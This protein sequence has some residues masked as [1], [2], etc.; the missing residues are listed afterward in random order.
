MF[1]VNLGRYGSAEHERDLKECALS[2]VAIMDI[3]SIVSTAVG[4]VPLPGLKVAFDTFQWIWSSV[5]QVQS[6]KAQLIQL[7]SAIAELLTTLQGNLRASLTPEQGAS[8]K[9]LQTLLNEISSFVSGLQQ[10]HFLKALFRKDEVS[11]AITA[12]HERIYHACDAF[13]ISSQINLQVWLAQSE[14]TKRADYASL[15]LLLQ[16][17]NYDQVAMFDLLNISD[18]KQDTL[19]TMM[20]AL[21]QAVTRISNNTERMFMQQAVRVIQRYSTSAQ[22][23]NDLPTWLVT[24]WEVDI[25]RKKI[26]AGGFGKV[27]P[28][29]WH[30]TKVAIK[31]LDSQTSP[32]LL[33]QEV[34]IWSK[35]LHPHVLQFLGAAIYEATPFLVMPLM[36]NGNCLDYIKKNP[37]ADRG[38]L[39]HQITLG[40]AYL[41][42]RK[43]PILHGDLK[44]VNVLVNASGDAILADFGLSRVNRDI[45]TRSSRVH[46]A[47]SL[48]WMAPE[49]LRSGKLTTETDVYAFALTVFEIYTEAIPFGDIDDSM[50]YTLVVKEDERP[51]QHD[52]DAIP[53]YSIDDR[54][55]VILTRAW[56][57]N[58]RQR[59]SA[60]QLVD[61]TA[62]LLSESSRPAKSLS[63]LP[64]AESV[65]LSPTQP[66][67]ARDEATGTQKLPTWVELAS[68]PDV[69]VQ[70]QACEGLIRDL[71]ETPTMR[72][73]TE[74]LEQLI[75]LLMSSDLK[76]SNSAASVL[77]L[78]T[79]VPSY[80]WFTRDR[81]QKGVFTE[82]HARNCIAGGALLPFSAILQRSHDKQNLATACYVVGNLGFFPSSGDALLRAKVIPLI[83]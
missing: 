5:V 28:A 83:T 7:A 3:P 61:M 46:T 38:L 51:R 16:K 30:G 8:L 82:N 57:P 24:S 35:L 49:R 14:S 67:E 55:W 11:A 79:H 36:I 58:P 19:L 54:V 53:P 59:P 69:R 75:R 17:M 27:Y 31:E 52:E 70:L 62:T 78:Y 15:E 21:Q 2:V 81:Y 40:L 10:M 74:A 26:G 48:R 25:E 77:G 60:V 1:V 66:A 34:D 43:P 37:S 29:K 13:N 18:T 50:L 42:S 22:D 6:N 12:Y 68:S 45:S 9:R 39:V 63:P 76:V 23:V 71:R 20:I 44:A 73:L 56:D 64:P 47:G 4:C 72:L 33:K 80:G 41:H 32:E 65:P